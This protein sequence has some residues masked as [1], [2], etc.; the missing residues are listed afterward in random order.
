MI[1][2]I[3]L[4]GVEAWLEL[5]KRP[6]LHLARKE[7]SEPEVK[8]YARE[9]T[10]ATTTPVIS[11]APAPTWTTQIGDV[12]TSSATSADQAL[13]LLGMLPNLPPEGQFQVAQHASRLMPTENFAVLGKFTIMTWA[14]KNI[15]IINPTHTAP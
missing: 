8:V 7:S 10:I 3:A 6:W 11:S 4:A 9:A 5:S 13:T 1:A 14:G 12:L 2:G 15:L